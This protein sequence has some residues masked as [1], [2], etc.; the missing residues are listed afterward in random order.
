MV[1]RKWDAN[2]IDKSDYAR[3]IVNALIWVFMSVLFVVYPLYFKNGYESIAS[4]KYRFYFLLM[5]YFLVTLLAIMIVA[6]SIW[7]F[8]KDALK[9]GK[10]FY[11]LV[12]VLTFYL[13]TNALSFIFSDYK[14]IRNEQLNKDIPWFIKG[15]LFGDKG[16][17]MGLVTIVIMTLCTLV[18][19]FIWNY[20]D[21]VFILIFLGSLP[22]TIWGLLNRYD[23]YPIK[24]KHSSETFISTLGNVDW[25]SGYLSIV[26]PLAYGLYLVSQSKVK[27]YILAFLSFIFI[28]MTVVSGAESGIFSL[29]V[30]YFI[31]LAIAIKDPIKLSRFG[32]LLIIFLAVLVYVRLIDKFFPDT[33]TLKEGIS[34]VM[35]STPFICLLAVIT[36]SLYLLLYLLGKRRSEYPMILK[37][38]GSSIVLLCGLF[39]TLTVIILMVVN[40]YVKRLPL[41]GESPY[42]SLGMRWGSTRGVCY[43]LA[44]KIFSKEGFIHKLFGVGPDS[45]SYAL[46]SHEDLSVISREYLWKLRLTNAHNE[47][48]TVLVNE[49]IVGVISFA[50]MWIVFIWQAI[51]GMSKSPLSGVFLLTFVSYLSN[52]MF[53]F[54]QVES[55]PFVYTIMGIF[56]A[57]FVKV[58]K[59]DKSGAK[60]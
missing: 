39:V 20:S 26:A 24:M 22:V 4:H 58:H 40:T 19:G 18:T 42:F 15:A 60:D 56:M 46:Y 54:R 28:H 1:K 59:V 51:K 12:A 41:I 17:Y 2:R 29:L 13:L 48:L 30:T 49:G 6:A 45:F 9:N 36:I 32:K 23:I 5:E 55:T 14:L 57:M 27:R 43:Y 37:K 38:R 34:E 50:S 44:I 7:G 47:L 35:I 31:M 52:N 8:S 25:F 16:W 53:S 21:K 33:R 11:L 10:P 3:L